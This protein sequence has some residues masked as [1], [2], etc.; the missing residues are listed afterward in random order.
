MARPLLCLIGWHKWHRKVNDAGQSYAQC[1]R[2]GKEDN[3]DR[4]TTPF[5]A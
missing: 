5:G 3:A 4:P 1:A 2:C